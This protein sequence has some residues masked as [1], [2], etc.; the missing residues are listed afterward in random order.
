M[1]EK[2]KQPPKGCLYGCLGVIVLFVLIL[3]CMVA[4][5]Q[6]ADHD[7]RRGPGCETLTEMVNNPNCKVPR[8]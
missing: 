7:Y 6:S 3:V 8:R 1:A 5:D 2:K 4:L